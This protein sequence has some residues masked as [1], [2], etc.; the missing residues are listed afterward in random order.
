MASALVSI[1]MDLVAVDAVA[2][3]HGTEAIHDILLTGRQ[4]PPRRRDGH[5]LALA[6]A[7]HSPTSRTPR[8]ETQSSVA[9]ALAASRVDDGAWA[10]HCL[11]RTLLGP[12]PICRV[13]IPSSFGPSRRPGRAG[14]G[15]LHG[16]NQAGPPPGP[17]SRRSSPHD[18]FVVLSGFSHG[19][20][21]A[22]EGG[23][24][25]FR[26][27][28]PILWSAW[29]TRAR[30]TQKHRTPGRRAGACAAK[31]SRSRKPDR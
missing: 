6:V 21:L 1:D 5:L 11:R 20:T 19:R 23:R 8:A 27:P 9:L 3:F 17:A 10:C 30:R 13:P 16:R 2:Y 24:L 18:G 28:P 4:N 29:L 26:R 14:D 22:L 12:A 25:R 7:V 15:R 31:R